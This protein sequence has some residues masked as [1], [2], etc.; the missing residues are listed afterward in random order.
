MLMATQLY[1]LWQS[2]LQY[3]KQ[4]ETGVFFQKEPIALKLAG[5]II[6]LYLESYFGYGVFVWPQ[7]MFKNN[8]GLHERE[9]ELQV[10][11]QVQLSFASRSQ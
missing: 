10:V 1:L 3:A 6:Q 8:K 7:V 11:G 4:M 9:I 2:P 5:F